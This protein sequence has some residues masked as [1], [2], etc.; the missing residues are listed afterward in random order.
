MTW[1]PASF[2][3]PVYYYPRFHLFACFLHC[4]AAI[5]HGLT[6]NQ[7]SLNNP[8][9]INGAISWMSSEAYCGTLF[10]G[11]DRIF[12]L[13]HTADARSFEPETHSSLAVARETRLISSPVGT[14]EEP[15]VSLLHLE[16]YSL[17]HMN[18]GSALQV[19]SYSLLVWRAAN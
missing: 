15:I 5:S 19:I 9:D 13:H 1:S 14:P 18:L 12:V 10:C 16:E 8:L 6:L 3:R 11:Y 4:G 7:P 2:D 17:R